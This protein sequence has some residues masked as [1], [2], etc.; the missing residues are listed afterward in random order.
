MSGGAGT[1]DGGEGV[2]RERSVA[3]RVLRRVEEGAYADRALAAEARRAELDPRARAQATR[4]AYGA[5]Q[6]RRTLDWLIDGALDRPAALEPAVRDILRLGAYELAFSDGVPA[7]AAVDQAVRQARAL[8]GP[9]ARASARAGVVNAV[10][11]RIAADAG[12]R[13][14]ALE[15]EGPEALALRHSM[16]DWIVER[17][18]ASLGHADAVGVMEAAAR[19]AESALRWNPLRGPRIDLE[20]ELPA[21]WRRDDAMAP[22]AY[23]LSAPF[24]L[25]DSAAW[26][27]GLAMG[28]S[29]ASQL[30]ARAVDPRPGERVL[31]MCA[32]PGAKTTH[33]AALARGGAR[34]TAIELRPRRADALR[35]LARRMGAVV[36]VI[37][38]DALEV[39][40]GEG[41]DAVLLDPPCTGL[42]VLSSRPDARWRRREEALGPLADLQRALLRRALAL[43]RPGGR[44]VYSTCTLIAEE[45]EDVVRAAGAP[46][47][48]LTASH[49][50]LAHPRLPGALLTLPHRDGTDGFF[51]ARLRRP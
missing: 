6:R 20:R 25:E 32:A 5:V 38:G 36:D 29:R 46:I 47:D 30:V 51:V 14:R 43:V 50:R 45:N 39:D 11:R 22:E 18:V 48:D 8:R 17:L 40:P 37:E 1:T 9:K 31:D 7:H 42:G 27:R 15:G 28:Q 44:V 3:L 4:L 34:I 24:A 21:G 49:P 41:F 23:V 12:P 33:M 13:L 19:P 10:M 26:A 2:A 35:A 16:P